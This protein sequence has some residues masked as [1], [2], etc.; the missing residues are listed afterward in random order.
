MALSIKKKLPIH[1][2]FILLFLWFVITQNFSAFFIFVTVVM[3]HELG[4]YVVA[5]KCG[6]KLDS[7]FL[8]PYGVSL[9][10][11]EKAFEPNDEIKIALAGPF[12]NIFLAI[13]AIAVWWIFPSIYG[14]TSTFVKQSVLLGLTNLLP[15]YP[16]DG[17]RILVG[18]LSIKN[19]RK[20]SIKIVVLLN[21][22]FSL[23]TLIL[24]IVSCFINFNPTFALLSCFLI[25]GVIQTK[26]ESKYRLASVY[27]KRTKDFSKPISFVVNSSVTLGE[28]IKH[29][30]ENKFTIFYCIFENGKTRIIDEK[31]LLILSI[32]YPY[33]ATMNEIYNTKKPS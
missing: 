33:T 30:E 14:F 25:G 10:Y 20:K 29:I 31:A 17:G 16:L 6:Y 12:V 22:L 15:C 3:S 4:H 5:K 18:A 23:F 19:E 28:M 11:K 13:V 1:P 24:F 32:K 21:Y 27:K 8:A 2:S 9:N 7:F 26:F